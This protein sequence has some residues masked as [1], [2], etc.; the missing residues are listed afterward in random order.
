MESNWS[1]LATTSKAALFHTPF[2]HNSL[3]WQIAGVVAHA[4]NLPASGA[5]AGYKLK[6]SVGRTQSSL[7]IKQQSRTVHPFQD[8]Q[9]PTRLWTVVF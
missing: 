7:K 8:S 4:W 6:P 9:N 5:E 2:S 3:H 1:L